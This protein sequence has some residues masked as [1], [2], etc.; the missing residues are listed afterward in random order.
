[1][2]QLPGV[3]SR[4]APRGRHRRGTGIGLLTMPHEAHTDRIVP[5]RRSGLTASRDSKGSGAVYPGTAS[6]DALVVRA[7]PVLAPFRDVAKHVVQAPAIR[8]LGRDA[9]WTGG[10]SGACG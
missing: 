5:R 4:C 9:L 7:V 3:M 1:M 2:E 8:R 6:Y 10:A